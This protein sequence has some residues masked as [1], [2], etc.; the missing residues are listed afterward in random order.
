MSTSRRRQALTE[1][2]LGYVLVHGLPDLSLRPLAASLDTSDR[3][4]I[5]HF[6]SKDGLLDAVLDLA[7]ARLAEAFA[8]LDGKPRTGQE[9]VE[10]AW[11][12]LTLP[13]SGAISG[14][15]FEVCAL[16]LRQPQR[17][18]AVHHRLRQPWL[19]LVH[20]DLCR[21]GIAADRAT[22]L[23][24]LVVDALDGL[25]LDRLVSGDTARIDAAVHELGL[26]LTRSTAPPP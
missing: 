15:Y 3:M 24:T 25:A 12:L 10:R 2:A 18:A 26:L 22:A 8:T 5:Y 21:L 9:V 16:S 11:R 1:A 4:L 6:G 13:R 17:W 19:R 20:D 23:A 14:L 7:N